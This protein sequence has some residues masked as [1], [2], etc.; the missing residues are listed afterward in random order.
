LGEDYDWFDVFVRESRDVIDR[1]R[2]G[3]PFAVSGEDGRRALEVSL[4]TL[5]AAQQRRPVSLPLPVSPPS[6]E[7]T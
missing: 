5:R 4:A 2:R 7:I 3:L 6:E 1:V